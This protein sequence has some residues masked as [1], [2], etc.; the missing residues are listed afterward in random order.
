MMTK[1]DPQDQVGGA[2]ITGK[3][4]KWRDGGR[5]DREMGKCQ[6]GK[7]IFYRYVLDEFIEKLVVSS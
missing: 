3:G 7:K 1:M 4:D 2:D 5:R 6:K